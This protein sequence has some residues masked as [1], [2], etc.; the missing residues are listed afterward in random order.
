MGGRRRSAAAHG[1]RLASESCKFGPLVATPAGGDSS[2]LLITLEGVRTEKFELAFR[3]RQSGEC[4]DRG[5]AAPGDSTMT[6]NAEAPSKTQVTAAP[7][8]EPRIVGGP[9]A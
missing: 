8:A 9:R 6:S 2:A 4:H 7:A 5:T 1:R 3:S